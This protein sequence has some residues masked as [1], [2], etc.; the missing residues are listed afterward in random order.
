MNSPAMNFSISADNLYGRDGLERLD[1]LF[2]E[3]IEVCAA[4]LAGQLM[5]ARTPESADR[6]APF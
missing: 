1:K 6:D 4:P 3:S 5:A 2:I